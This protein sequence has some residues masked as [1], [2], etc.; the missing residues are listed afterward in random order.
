M[1]VHPAIG[2]KTQQVQPPAG[3]LSLPHRLLQDRVRAERSIPNCPADPGK[4]LIHDAAGADIH[5]ADFG[6]SHLVVRKSGI[7]SGRG[8]QRVRIVF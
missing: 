3:C 4:V 7:F 1:T 8:K 5:M 2:Q 6:I